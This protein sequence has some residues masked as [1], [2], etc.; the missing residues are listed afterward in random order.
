VVEVLSPANT[1]PEQAQKLRDY[2]SLGVPEVW[3]LSPE[4]ETLEVLQLRDPRLVTTAL[5]RERTVTRCIF[6]KPWWTSPQFFRRPNSRSI[7]RQR[8]ISIGWRQTSQANSRIAEVKL[9]PE[10]AAFGTGFRGSYKRDAESL[11]LH[12]RD[13]FLGRDLGLWRS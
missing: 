13:M 11:L 5:L 9:G 10:S 12:S 6:S 1:P 7:C 8:C 4:A 2:E 3:V